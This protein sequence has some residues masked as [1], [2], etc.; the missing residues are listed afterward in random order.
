MDNIKCEDV[1]RQQPLT[2]L[3][4][5]YIGSHLEQFDII[6]NSFKLET[7]HMNI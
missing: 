7:T 3:K 4:A 5:A 6:H 1:G 2:Q